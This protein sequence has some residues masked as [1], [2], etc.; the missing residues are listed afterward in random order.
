MSL[1]ALG[2]IGEPVAFPATVTRTYAIELHNP[3]AAPRTKPPRP[4][5]S[6]TT[7]RPLHT[8][9][10][11]YRE[12]LGAGVGTDGIGQRHALALALTMKT[13]RAFAPV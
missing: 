13:D 1:F 2:T 7:R 4:L 3:V 8:D 10:L 5:P 12:W 11:S 9:M 6:E